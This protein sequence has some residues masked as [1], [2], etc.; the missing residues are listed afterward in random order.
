MPYSLLMAPP[1]HLSRSGRWLVGTLK[2]FKAGLFPTITIL[3][4]SPLA[5]QQFTLTEDP[6]GV[7]PL[8]SRMAGSQAP[9]A[10]YF[11]DSTCAAA[12]DFAIPRIG[13]PTKFGVPDAEFFRF[14]LLGEGSPFRM[15]LTHVQTEQAVLAKAIKDGTPVAVVVDPRQDL[16]L[17]CTAFSPQSGG[18][19][20]AATTDLQ[21]GNLPSATAQMARDMFALLW[22]L[23]S[24]KD[25]PR[26]PGCRGEGEH[27]DDC[28]PFCH[29]GSGCNE[30]ANFCHH[31]LTRQFPT[32]ADSLFKMFTFETET[33]CSPNSPSGTDLW[34]QHIAPAI[35][36]G[37]HE[38]RV[39]DPSLF[40]RPVTIEEW[41]AR[42][43]PLSRTA[44]EIPPHIY[45]C[46]RGVWLMDLT[47][48]CTL[49]FMKLLQYRLDEM[50]IRQCGWPPYH[51]CCPS[52]I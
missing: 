8:I 27:L 29:S 26:C 13:I 43:K 12:L 9:A 37:R 1:L 35:R 39:L 24:R 30:R 20:L 7:A 4:G 5:S 40:S 49:I 42:F 44:R 23:R 18:C 25:S 32:A 31:L 22:S 14:A 38:V 28:I 36:V 33:F 11:E 6:Y 51:C 50:V 46:D 47:F 21:I 17:H 10:F 3:A 2:E 41:I 52:E 19:Q 48:D 45:G 15:S 16:V 34:Q